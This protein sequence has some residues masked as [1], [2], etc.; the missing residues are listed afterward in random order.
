MLNLDE[1]ITREIKA[2]HFDDEYG[3]PSRGDTFS[4]SAARA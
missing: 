4:A 3:W 1:T 2:M